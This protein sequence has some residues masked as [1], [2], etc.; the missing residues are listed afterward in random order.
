MSLTKEKEKEKKKKKKKKEKKKRK[1][2]TNCSKQL[3]II[4]GCK[5]TEVTL[6]NKRVCSN[7][8][9]INITPCWVRGKRKRWE[10]DGGGGGGGDGGGG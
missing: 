8:C 5:E 10:W 3:V 7:L 6:G 9:I 4:V 1:K 2:K